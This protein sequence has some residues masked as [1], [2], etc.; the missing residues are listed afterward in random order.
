MIPRTT[1]ADAPRLGQAPTVIHVDTERGWRGGERQVLWLAQSLPRDR[2]RSI[3][4][5]RPGEPLLDRSAAAGIPVVPLTPF[6][7]FDALAALRLREVCRREHVSLVHAHTAHAVG[8][9]A[10]A[11]T[12][13]NVRL[14]VT[15]RVDFPLRAN[16]ATR[17]KY[18]RADALIAIS[19]AV[20]GVLTASGIPRERIEIVPSGVDLTRQVLPAS[21][22]VLAALGVP[23]G[24]PLVVQVA[25]LVP[26]KDPLTFVRAI[27]AVRDARP[28][29]HALLVGDGPL[30]EAVVALVAELELQSVLHVTGYRTDADAL[31]A[32][33][34]V[35]TLSSREEG[36]G[37]VLLDALALGKP[38]AATRAGGIGEIVEDGR[39]GRLVGVGDG[40]ALGRA[41]DDYLGELDDPSRRAAIAAAARQ[42]AAEFSIE[43]TADATAAVY[44]KVLA[45]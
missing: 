41:I 7:E 14:V 39:S 5:G 4:A 45:P 27:A 31:L 8:L 25:Q 28:D 37:T 9:A 22:D 18:R 6:A 13:T 12:R 42:R 40:A 29:V 23:R 11:L 38:V 20:A 33:G 35:V 3:V 32:A 2:F 36:L 24:A 16:P 19:S 43:R 10:L 21:S 34:E 1:A 30:R 26:H 44:E 17:W 15:R